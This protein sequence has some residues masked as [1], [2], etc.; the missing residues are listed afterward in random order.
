MPEEIKS[1]EELIDVGETTGAEINLDDK[2]EAVKQE[3]IKEEI[4]VEQIPEDKTY[5]NEKQ[6]K[7][8]KKEEPDELKEYSEGVQKR[9]AK[10]TRKMRE[11]ERQREEAVN[12]AQTIKQQKD[13]AENR[14]SKLDKSYVSEFE[15]RVTTS[16]AAAKLALK[17][18]IES[19]NVEAQIAAQEQLANLTVENARL[20]A[21]KTVE[22]E[23]PKQK[24]VNIAPQ[25]TPP[26]PQSDPKAED[27][28][29]KNAWFGNDTAMTYTAFDI[30][31]KLVEEE[32]FD[33]KSDEYY[34]EVDSR[35]RLEFP[36]KFD[37]VSSNTT[38]RAKPA[39][40]VASAK[41]SATTG[42][43]KTVRLSPSQVAIAK[44]L[45]VPLEDYAKQLNITEGV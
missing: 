39:Q 7:L 36:H 20:N 29:S 22:Q 2:G 27:W 34:E 10:L 5:E 9:I 40:A 17:N 13:Q 1:S 12:Y 21:L 35:I 8:E 41:R 33:P 26:T 43:K 42:R 11:A 16:M 19:Q 32:G 24:E 14:L 28:A 15:S 31:K 25:R 6:V 37:K 3:E 23:T 44:R 45:G 38:E 18:A 4:E 30:H